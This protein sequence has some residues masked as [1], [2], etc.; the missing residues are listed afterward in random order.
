MIIDILC[1]QDRRV[2]TSV[3]GLADHRSG[4]GQPGALL[5]LLHLLW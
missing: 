2:Q 5:R 3:V 4:G 1:P